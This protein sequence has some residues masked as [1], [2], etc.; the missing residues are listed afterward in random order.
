MKNS[1]GN[2]RPSNIPYSSS[3]VK[4]A[5]VFAIVLCLIM[6]GIAI[7]SLIGGGNEGPFIPIVPIMATVA[8]VMGMFQLRKVRAQES[9]RQG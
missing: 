2:T 4:V 8:V 6:W 7:A 1:G 5:L 9:D 3:Q